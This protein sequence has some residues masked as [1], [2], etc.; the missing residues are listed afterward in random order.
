MTPNQG[1]ALERK[2][3]LTK[4][5][6]LILSQKTQYVASELIMARE[7]CC[8]KCNRADCKMALQLVSRIRYWIKCNLINFQICR[9]MRKINRIHIEGANR[10]EKQY[11][12]A[13]VTPSRCLQY[14]S[15]ALNLQFLENSIDAEALHHCS[16]DVSKLPV[17]KKP[18]RPRSIT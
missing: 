16:G 2:I 18:N 8:K 13:T 5:M 9:K 17:N 12:Q 15:P 4:S 7:K 11:L 3:I 14:V 6:V 1:L 10:K